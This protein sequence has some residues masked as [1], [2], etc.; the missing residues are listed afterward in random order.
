MMMIPKIIRACGGTS[1]T[2][3]LFRLVVGPATE[4]GK[5]ID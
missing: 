2:V 3:L 5:L 1:A 4:M